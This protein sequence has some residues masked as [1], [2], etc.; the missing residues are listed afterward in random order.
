MDKMIPIYWQNLCTLPRKSRGFNLITAEIQQSMT[1][2]PV[3]QTGLAHLFLQHTSASLT[4]SENT[5]TDVPIDLEAY[6]N[7]AIPDDERLYRHILEGADDMPAHIKNVLLGASLTIPI[8]KGQ[9]ALGQWQGIYL[10]E[11]RNHADERRI[12]ITVH[13]I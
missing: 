7:R 1:T 10:C 13:G 12:V 4:I 8:S 6:F 5:C 3:V 11:H 2:M 9:L